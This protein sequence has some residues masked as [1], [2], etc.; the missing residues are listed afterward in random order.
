MNRSSAASSR[1]S[2][3]A[4]QDWRRA[5]E[6]IRRSLASKRSEATARFSRYAGRPAD[7]VDEVLLGF[8]WSKQREI[9][10]SVMANRHTA[11]KA[12]HDV[13]KSYTAATLA[14]YWLTVHEPGTAFVVTLAP[15]A[16]QVKG[17]LWREMRSIARRGGLPGRLNQ[18]EWYIGNSLVG[19]GRSP[20]DDAPTSVQGIHADQ[21][22]GII[23]EADGVG[24]LLFDALD[25]MCANDDSRVLAIGNPDNP[26]SHFARVCSPGS[27][28]NTITI[29]AFDSPNLTGEEV[30]DW[31]RKKLV[32]RT[33]VEERRKRWGERSP[34]YIS[35]V[36]GE[37]PSDVRGALWT[38]AMIAD[39]Q[40]PPEK[41]LPQM[42]RIVVAID[43]SGGDGSSEA[44]DP[45]GIVVAGLGVD[46]VAYV[47]SDVTVNLGP[48]GWARRAVEAFDAF[49]ADTFVAEVNFGGA[50]VSATIRSVRRTAPVR[51]VRASRGKMVRAEPVSALYAQGLVKH[52]PARRNDKGRLVV[53]Q[54]MDLGP[55]EAEM[56]LAT[57]TGYGGANSPNRLDA[58]VWAITEL[59]LM[60]E[61][62]FRTSEE[63]FVI[64]PLRR[65]PNFWPKVAVLDISPGRMSVI[66]A[67]LDEEAD[68]V[69]VYA[70]WTSPSQPLPVLA[71]AIRRRGSMPVVI[72]PD[73]RGRSKGEGRALL[74][75]LME[76]GVDVFAAAFD[77]EAG[78]TAVGERLSSG[79]LKVY[80]SAA[81]TLAGYRNWRRDEDGEIVEED[82]HMMRL[83]TALC[84][85]A[86][87]VA[88]SE[89]LP[90][91]G[92]W[93][94][95]TRSTT[96]G[97]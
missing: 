35:K 67:A 88:S 81:A 22:L 53:D 37:F 50:M 46:G 97:Y 28:W 86:I 20:K 3:L 41:P 51:E 82:D 33:W 4:L 68:V 69:T 18:T 12:A 91:Q 44:G 72:D 64:Q 75:Q 47:L 15:T 17:I 57:V 45:Q 87:Q 36:L 10:D 56:K 66:W 14:A 83:L 30:P 65:L 9:Y 39:A 71:D 96:T 79:R 52:A 42:Q 55:L 8:S 90:D 80:D 95:R 32:S 92:D 1:Q 94:D 93:S 6:A 74:A 26:G 78:I 49:A 54:D 63:E 25:T 11:V 19:F 43:P 76:A 84:S 40:H 2:V 59:M 34:R 29:S 61:A 24:E 60:G 73:A 38:V 7:F 70:E 77:L 62:V 89:P 48:I 85:S 21:V 27:G 23:D 58:M 31:L 13:S 5:E 16:H